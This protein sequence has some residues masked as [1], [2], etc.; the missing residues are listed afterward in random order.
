MKNNS[1]F[2]NYCCDSFESLNSTYIVDV[3]KDSSIEVA[4]LFHCGFKQLYYVQVLTSDFKVLYFY[5]SNL[6]SFCLYR[7]VFNHRHSSKFFLNHF[8]I[9]LLSYDVA[10]SCRSSLNLKIVD[11]YANM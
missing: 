8:P 6:N 2:S 11:I 7:S 1:L 4:T 9:N 10:M 5:F 3:F